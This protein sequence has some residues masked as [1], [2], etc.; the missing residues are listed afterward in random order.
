MMTQMAV[1]RPFRALRPAPD[2]VAAVLAPPYDVV[3]VAQASQ[4]AAGNPVSLLHVTRPEIDLPDGTDPSG[5]QAHEAARTALVHL[6]AS[7]VLV[8]EATEAFLAYRLIRDGRAQTGV[9]GCAAVADYLTGAIA[10][11]EKTRTQKEADR[12]EHID[13]IDAHDESVLLM[14][15]NERSGSAPA[16]IADVL[17][18]T[19][20]RRPWY[21]LSDPDGVQH[22]VWPVAQ[23]DC[24]LIESA[25]ADIP[26]LYIA[27]G[28]HR[29]AAAAL[30][31]R[32]RGGSGRSTLFP[33][34]A[35]P[36]DELT[37]LPY[38]RVV[39]DLGSYD[40][41]TFLAALGR[42][43]EVEPSQ[44]PVQPSERW[45]FGV[46]LPSGWYLA[47]L[48]A[49]HARRLTD[50]SD[51]VAALDVD[52]L[53]KHVLEPLLGIG[54]PRTDP[55]IAFVGGSHG[56]PELDRLVRTSTVAVAFSLTATS[57]ADVMAI[58][59]AGLIM[60]PKSTWFEP[61]LGSGLFLHALA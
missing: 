6:V 38:H 18:R 2:Q 20:A 39:H 3:D 27:D 34:V 32:R 57:P 37:V 13:A 50:A 48:K 28:H 55:R 52:V 31:A 11:H 53:A 25:F 12:V 59:D 54:D 22:T 19:T 14:Y 26:R 33:V 43:F 1:L 45:T 35:F 36:D 9:V 30:V 60:P 58:A 56:A 15:R 5:P 41:T 49:V 8:Q 23:G 4:R 29:S 16:R 24:P 40:E 47:R 10:V 61:K 42:D 21:D 46:R 7:G 44:S 51:V 17:E